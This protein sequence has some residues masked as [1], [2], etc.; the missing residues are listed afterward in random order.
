VALFQLSFGLSFGSLSALFRLSFGSLSAL[1]QLSFSSLSARLWILGKR[2]LVKRLFSASEKAMPN[3]CSSALQKGISIKRLKT[4]KFRLCELF[5]NLK[6]LRKRI[7]SMQGLS[8]QPTIF[9]FL[10]PLPPH[11]PLSSRIAKLL[12]GKS[13]RYSPNNENQ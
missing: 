7:C 12:F 4:I 2:A 10:H 3:L 8:E 11:V 6:I 13:E 9:R 5:E 1:F